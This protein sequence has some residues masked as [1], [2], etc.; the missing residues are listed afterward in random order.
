MPDFHVQTIAP[1]IRVMIPKG[2]QLVGGEANTV[3]YALSLKEAKE[4]AE[5]LNQAVVDVRK[6]D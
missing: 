6:I 3:C 1:A 2:R 4:L 5:A